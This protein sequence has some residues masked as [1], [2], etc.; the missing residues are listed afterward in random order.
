MQWKRG[1]RRPVRSRRRGA[2]SPRENGSPE[3][4]LRADGA[5]NGSCAG[6]RSPMLRGT[7]LIALLLAL[8]PAVAR[9]SGDEPDRAFGQRGTVTL[10][11]TDADAVG[12]AVKVIAGHKVLA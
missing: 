3:E 10:K 9:A 1:P 7:V 8:A 6:W 11:A 5:P 12:G 4:N 2:W